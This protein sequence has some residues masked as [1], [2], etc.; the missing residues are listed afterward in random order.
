MVGEYWRR[1]RDNTRRLYT[2][3]GSKDSAISSTPLYVSKRV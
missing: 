1:E 3:D 2:D